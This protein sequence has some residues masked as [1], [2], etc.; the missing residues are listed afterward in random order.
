MCCRFFYTKTI[1]QFWMKHYL[2]LGSRIFK[3]LWYSYVCVTFY[4][5]ITAGLYTLLFASEYYIEEQNDLCG[6]YVCSGCCR[7]AVRDRWPRL[8]RRRHYPTT[9]LIDFLPLKCL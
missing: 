4:F 8:L 2:Y 3:L 9:M 5:N 1:G 6:G 7:E